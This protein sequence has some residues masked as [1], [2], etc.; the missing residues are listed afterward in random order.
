V[1]S[2]GSKKKMVREEVFEPMQKADV[3][4]NPNASRDSYLGAL[5]LKRLILRGRAEMW[6]NNIYTVVV[7]LL[8]KDRSGA[9]HLSIRRNDRDVAKDWRHFQ[10]IKNEIIGD[11]RG[12]RNIP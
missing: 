9:M 3:V 10:R 11:E 1:G 6:V 5:E 4:V 2:R 12:H 8:D 7:R